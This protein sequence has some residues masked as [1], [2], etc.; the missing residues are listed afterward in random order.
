MKKSITLLLL[1]LVITALFASCTPSEEEQNVPPAS[2]NAVWGAGIDTYLVVD[3]SDWDVF[4]LPNKLQSYVST[5]SGSKITLRDKSNDSMKHIISLGDTG[6]AISGRA[7]QALDDLFNASSAYDSGTSSWLIYAESGSLAIAYT[8]T[9]AKIEAVNYIMTR[10]TDSTYEPSRGLVYSGSFDTRERLDVLRDE[11]RKEELVYV[12]TK[13]GKSAADAL[14]KLYSLYDEELYVW[15]ANLYCPDVGG[16]YYS[17]SARDN[18]GF[19]PDLESTGQALG[20]LGTAG[21]AQLYK[22]PVSDDLTYK[23]AAM[24]PYEIRENILAFSKS[25]QDTDGYFY[26]P[27]WGTGISSSRKGR[28]AGW[29][30]RIILAM[31]SKPNYTIKYDVDPTSSLYPVT[32]SLGGSTVVAVSKVVAT[33]SES[34]NAKY[35][36][37]ENFIAYLE[38]LFA[39]GNSYSAGNE[40]N[41]T[42]G[43]I[44]GHKLRGTLCNWLIEKQNKENGLWEDEVSYQSVNGLMKLCGVFG[45]NY[46]SFPNPERALDSAMEIMKR[47]IDDGLDAITT[48]YNPWVAMYNLLNRVGEEK[49]TALRDELY[50]N[51]REIF[52]MMAQKLALF[53][54]ADGGFSYNLE[55]SAAYSQ[56]SLVAVS[57]SAESDVN[58][59]SIAIS[60]VVK[61]MDSVFGLKFPEI[62]S[63]YDS[64]Y[65]LETMDRMYSIIKNRMEEPEVE[66]FDD[67]VASDSEYQGN[68]VLTPGKYVTN[69]IGDTG[70]NVWFESAVVQNPKSEERDLVLWSADRTYPDNDKKIATEASRNEFKIS[71]FASVGNCY[72]FEAD[73][74]FTSVE[75]AS[76][77]LAQ[78]TFVREET[79]LISAWVDFYQYERFGQKYIRIQE[80]FAGADGVKDSEVVSGL[81]VDEWFN[82]RVEMYKEFSGESAQLKTMLKFYVNGTLAGISDSGHYEKGAYKDFVVSAVRLSYYRHTPS[83]IYLNNVLAAKTGQSYSYEGM[84]GVDNTPVSDGKLVFGFDDGIPNSDGF[85][86]EMFYNHEDDGLTSINPCD[87]TDPLDKLYGTKGGVKLYSVLDPESDVNKVIKAYSQNT[88]SSAYDAT[89]YVQEQLL[90]EG[91]TTWE[92]E[93]DYY[94]EKLSWL[95]ADKFFSL[96]LQNT[97]GASIASV[98]FNGLNWEDTNNTDRLGISLSNGKILDN[99]VLS[100]ATWYTFKV[101]YHYDSANPENSMILIYILGASGYVCVA[102]E[103]VGGKAGIIDRVGFNFHCYKIRGT[104][105]I[106]DVS[107]SRTNLKYVNEKVAEGEIELPNMVDNKIYV[108]TSSRGEGEYV[109]DAISYS[110]KSFEQLVKDKKLATSVIRGDGVADNN[111]TLKTMTYE[112]SAVLYYSALA[113]GNHAF[114]FMAQKPA[115]EGLIFET[116]IKLVGVDVESGRDIRFTATSTGGAV[117]ADIWCFNLKIHKNPNEKIGGYIV[118]ISGSDRRVVIKEAQWYNLR[119]VAGG[120]DANSPL[121]LFVNGECVIKTTLGSDGEDVNLKGAVGV[122]LYT[123]ATYGGQGWEMG[124]IYLDNTYVS[125]LGTPPKE[126]TVQDSSRGEGEYADDAVTYEG[127]TYEQ[128]VSGGL[129]INN[130]SRGDGVEAKT[131]ELLVGST[132]ANKSYLS[133]KAIGSGIQALNFACVKGVYTNLVFETDIKLVGVDNTQ[134]RPIR[135]IASVYN[136]IKDADSYAFALNIYANRDRD[137]GG[138]IVTVAGSY[139]KVYIKDDT[140]VNL[141]LVASGLDKGSTL[142]LFVNGDECITTTITEKIP[143]NVKGVELYTPS[144]YN[145]AHGWENGE[146]QLDNTYVGGFG[147]APD[148]PK[149][150]ES[151][152]DKGQNKDNAINYSGTTYEQLILGGK[153]SENTYRTDGIAD[154]NRNLSIKNLD[155]NLALVYGA[156]NSSNNAINFKSQSPAYTGFVFETDLMLDGVNCDK[157]RAISFI[158]TYN[159]GKGAADL[160]AF[161]IK[162]Y[163]NPEISVGGYILTVGSYSCH[164]TDKTWFNICF[165]ASF[166]ETSTYSFYVNGKKVVTDVKLSSNMTAI[167]GVELYTPSSSGGIGF[168]EGEIYLD[169]TYVS[170][171]GE[172]PKYNNVVTETQRG[173]GLYKDY[174]ISYEG[175][176]YEQLILDGKMAENTYRTEGLADNKRTL[177]FEEIGDSTAMVYKAVS[178]A[179]CGMN[180]VRDTT[181]SNR[182]FVFE[183]DIMLDGVSNDTSRPI[184]FFGSSAY[185]SGEK[186]ELWGLNIKIYK[187]PN[188]SEG[189]YVI[190]LNGADDWKGLI[191]EATW[192][193]IRFEAAETAKG[194]AFSFYINGVKVTSGSLTSSISSLK[195]VELSTL[196]NSGGYGFVEGSIYL[197]NTYVGGIIKSQ[198]ETGGNFDSGNI[199]GDA[200]DD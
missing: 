8:D 128:L 145:G 43:A 187:N 10:I 82:L 198:G 176:T 13:L 50:K 152:R 18:E 186:K 42:I 124:G 67:F 136:G 102:N 26:H 182:G 39:S 27:Q 76:A 100:D 80:Y 5:L 169:N 168:T 155:G 60:T 59:T 115:M 19:L 195:S 125:G 79:K 161:N 107:V 180:F 111:R 41:A 171:T 116:D 25:L 159:N 143:A 21:I 16:F 181:L 119:L 3:G 110:G 108:D 177:S 190:S 158:G 14:I 140:W 87:W 154:G 104:Q 63:G 142:K 118:T 45:G 84:S 30:K 137:V 15:L 164:I 33:A 49:K 165:E 86:G 163:K 179:Y 172:A 94:F 56:G 12:E 153:M 6:T 96:E 193:N 148:Y 127:I 150:T 89:L 72:V 192:V 34:D 90:S 51:S 88:E 91:G 199:D 105:Y 61:Y 44:E 131:R 54:K 103:K 83:E 160:W 9:L 31:G 117:D 22:N 24:L 149:F 170:G 2:E 151:N 135:F 62:Y 129:M 109:K 167:K 162:I 36:S 4:S 184:S 174:A 138:Y 130:I 69:H 185:N 191:P 157:E 139:D 126:I 28:D 133:Y 73:M 35:A 120:V 40:I 197:D 68:V 113:S 77:P 122:E 183:T 112:G 85:F 123:P 134:T 144:T 46:P 53:K 7:Y 66:T 175:M 47:P 57:G 65:F 121:A 141:R 146:I 55:F 74:L 92:I 75:N 81:P 23:W 189:G 114:E 64:I 17:N 97:A 52:A 106:D 20:L 1:S 188:I 11:S 70:G 58:A 178:S 194:S 173:E 37:E 78:L 98:S 99:I 101:V 166:G 132:E 156:Q 200:W 32:G 71:N 93:F 48:V 38:E 147:D 196:S 29:G 95:F